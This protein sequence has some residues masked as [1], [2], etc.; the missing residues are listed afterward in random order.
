MGLSLTLPLLSP[1]PY[2][3]ISFLSCQ[4]PF[5]SFKHFLSNSVLSCHIHHPMY[6]F[7]LACLCL[8]PLPGWVLSSYLFRHP[9][10]QCCCGSLPASTVTAIPWVHTIPQMRA[11]QKQGQG[12]TER[13]QLSGRDECTWERETLY[14]VIRCRWHPE[15]RM[16]PFFNQLIAA[17]LRTHILHWSSSDQICYIN[18]N[19]I[20]MNHFIIV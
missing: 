6:L 10:F 8:L 11:R 15:L 1:S 2:A 13:R 16:K 4:C 18:K 7:F 12:G 3:A 19:S 20:R 5:A 14:V 17:A 9:R